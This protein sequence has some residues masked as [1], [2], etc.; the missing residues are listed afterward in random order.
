MRPSRSAASMI[1]IPMRSFTEPP[2][3]RKSTRLNSSHANIS[4][5]VFCLKKKTNN[6]QSILL[7]NKPLWNQRYLRPQCK[8]PSR[9][10]T[11]ITQHSHVL[12]N[13]RPWLRNAHSTHPPTL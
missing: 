6:L 11:E 7:T 1:G 13:S 5:A 2:G 3:D 9:A 12:T 8:L 4:Y 10:T